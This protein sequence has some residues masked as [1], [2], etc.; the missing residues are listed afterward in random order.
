MTKK[1][2]HYPAVS[3]RSIDGG[4][5]AVIMEAQ[6]AHPLYKCAGQKSISLGFEAQRAHGGALY[7][8]PALG[9]RL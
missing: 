6:R 7:K 2:K 8:Y 4:H 9:Q 1:A 5:V 3:G